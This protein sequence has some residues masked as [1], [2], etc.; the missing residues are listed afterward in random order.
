MHNINLVRTYEHTFPAVIWCV[1]RIL[2]INVLFCVLQKI[3]YLFSEC[4]PTKLS[5]GVLLKQ[6]KINSEP[7]NARKK[8]GV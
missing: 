2:N 7:K 4:T 5:F 1:M 8:S 6:K 3:T